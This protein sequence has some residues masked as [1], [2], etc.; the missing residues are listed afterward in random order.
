[1]ISKLDLIKSYKTLILQIPNLKLGRFLYLDSEFRF[2]IL[3]PI[4]VK[5]LHL[6]SCKSSSLILKIEMLKP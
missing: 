6:Y 5:C 2:N 3:I 4:K 1:M